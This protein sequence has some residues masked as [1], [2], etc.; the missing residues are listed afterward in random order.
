MGIVHTITLTAEELALLDRQDPSTE[1]DG[2]WQGLLVELQTRVRRSDR[3]I[4]LSEEDVLRIARYAFDYGQ[5]GWE[6]RLVGVFGRA[7]GPHLGRS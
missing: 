7:L 6:D 3:R 4:V 2:G 5:G 1:S